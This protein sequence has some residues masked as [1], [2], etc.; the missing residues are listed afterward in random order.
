[1][2]VVEQRPAPAVVAPEAPSG[3]RRG[4]H[5]LAERIPLRQLTVEDLGTL[6]ASALAGVS[7][8]WVLAT[9]VLPL[10]GR[11]GFWLLSYLA[12]LAFY[13]AVSGM[14]FGSRVVL[15]RI[16]SVLTTTGCLVV[17]GALVSL[18]G[19]I[20]VRGIS[21]LRHS[22][23][24]TESMSNAGPL[25]PMS[26]GGAFHA[27]V[28]SLEQLAIATAI[29]V[30]LGILAALYMAEVG[31]RMSGVVRILVDAM[32]ALPSIVAGLFVLSLYIV[33]LH[34]PAS[35]FAA[36]LAI[37]VMMLP[38]ITRASEVIIRLVPNSLRE[39]G[40]AL[41]SSQ[42]R[43]VWTVVLPTARSGLT[44]A[45]VLGM[46]RGIGETSPVLLTAGFTKELN[47]NPLSGQQA[48]LPLYIY[49]YVRFPQHTYID[50]AFGAA[51]LLM[52]IVFIL[53]VTARVLGGAAPGQ[54]TRRQ[55]RR[56]ATSERRAR[57]LTAS[58]PAPGPATDVAPGTP[59]T[60]LQEQP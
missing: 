19:Y 57:A 35:G 38:I 52:V 55:R 9:R 22:N 49:N 59:V 54:T 4:A 58:S 2:T 20:G 41:G 29:S 6:V 26:D 12:F 47:T 7:L 5:A 56:M 30:P 42:W 18:L 31:G 53:F 15:D 11:L 50:R 36:A 40:Y 16:S 48:N 14:Q 13:A 46:A 43:V 60:S 34:L 27:V 24:F 37:S 45:V 51:I 25:S 1:V 3:P 32:T 33:T 39:A 8:T 17:I 23:F 10:D 21:V 28:G 44:T